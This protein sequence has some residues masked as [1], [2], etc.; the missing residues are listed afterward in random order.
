M[1]HSHIGP[2]LISCVGSAWPELLMAKRHD[3]GTTAA[4]SKKG[5]TGHSRPA[6]QRTH[7]LQGEDKAEDAPVKRSAHE[8]TA[9]APKRRKQGADDKTIAAPP[10]P[11]PQQE[12]YQKDREH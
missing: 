11:R 4:A 2:N 9:P 3:D 5:D 7:S 12:R 10:Q 1:F 8:T 6:D